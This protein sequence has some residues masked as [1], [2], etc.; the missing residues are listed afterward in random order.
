VSAVKN[1][2]DPE[3][4]RSKKE[5]FMDIAVKDVRFTPKAGDIKFLFFQEIFAYRHMLFKSPLSL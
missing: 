1:E 5:N 2:Y 3:K 4:H